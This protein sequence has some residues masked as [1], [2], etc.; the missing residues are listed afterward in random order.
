MSAFEQIPA[1]HPA[2]ADAATITASSNITTSPAQAPPRNHDL[3][4]STALHSPKPHT[5]SDLGPYSSPPAKPSSVGK[6]PAVGEGNWSTSWPRTA[7]RDKPREKAHAAK[8][9]Q[10]HGTGRFERS[11]D[12]AATSVVVDTLVLGTSELGELPPR[13]RAMLEDNKVSQSWQLA[14]G[15]ADGLKCAWRHER[16]DM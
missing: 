8:P 3:L 9:S 7:S 6:L 15:R 5:S 1:I 11:C 16:L 2:I 13:L 14:A 4:P 10:E 12:A